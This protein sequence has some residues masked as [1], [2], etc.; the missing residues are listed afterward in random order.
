MLLVIFALITSTEDYKKRCVSYGIDLDNCQNLI[1]APTDN[2]DRF[3]STY[4]VPIIKDPECKE[5]RCYVQYNN[6]P[7][8]NGKQTIEG[9]VSIN[10]TPLQKKEKD[11]DV[12][13]VI[14]PIVSTVVVEKPLTLYREILTTS[15]V[16]IP[17]TNFKVTTVTNEKTVTKVVSSTETVTNTTTCTQTSTLTVLSTI[18]MT[19]TETKTVER[20]ETKTVERQEIKTVE[21]KRIEPDAEKNN[22]DCPEK[23]EKVFESFSVLLRPLIEQLKHIT[24][25][26]DDKKTVSKTVVLFKTLPPTIHTISVTPATENVRFTTTTVF[27]TRK[28][29]DEKC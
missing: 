26:G 5:K 1:Y 17:I 9:I 12:V 29:G 22:S 2:Y 23:K 28:K 7:K 24:A 15:T 19:K 18:N 8:N 4:N 10:I 21:A 25:E 6:G 11:A 14:R 13:T 27:S 3:L 20:Q 16:E